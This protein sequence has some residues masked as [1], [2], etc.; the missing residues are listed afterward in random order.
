MLR[1]IRVLANFLRDF[2]S[3]NCLLG[4]PL[5]RR[6]CYG[7]PPQFYSSWLPDYQR[8]ALRQH[9]RSRAKTR[10]LLQFQLRITGLIRCPR[11]GLLEVGLHEGHGFVRHGVFRLGILFLLVIIGYI[12]R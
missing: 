7:V 12:L 10:G 11:L 3:D 9:I 6:P 5:A 8:F 1:W 4:K 2:G